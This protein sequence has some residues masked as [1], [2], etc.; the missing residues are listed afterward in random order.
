MP[1][2]ISLDPSSIGV[3]GL[4]VFFVISLGTGR[5]YTRRQY[6]EAIHDR[7]EWRTESRLKD[8][9][10]AEKDDQLR[11]LGEVGRNVLAIMQ[12]LRATHTGGSGDGDDAT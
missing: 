7:D 4:C 3:V 2:G 1:E 9:Q 12:A 6:D 8:A 5:L 10:I 11:H